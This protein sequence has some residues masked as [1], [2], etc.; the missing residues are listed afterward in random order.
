MY[1]LESPLRLFEL[2]DHSTLPSCEVVS[3]SASFG[4]GHYLLYNECVIEH[5]RN[6]RAHS[7]R[8]ETPS[9]D[10]GRIEE[11]LAIC[12]CFMVFFLVSF[13]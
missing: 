4:T 10:F 1:Q 8:G 12:D 13:A 9:M 3:V 2:Y 7:G 5:S 6:W 11:P